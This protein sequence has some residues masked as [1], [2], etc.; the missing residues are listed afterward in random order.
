MGRRT[1]QT[2]RKVKIPAGLKKRLKK[3]KAEKVVEN[4]VVEEPLP[5]CEIPSCGCGN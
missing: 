2:Q 1:V 5:A 3:A 4:P